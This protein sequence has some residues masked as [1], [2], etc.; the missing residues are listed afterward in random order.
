[1]LEQIRRFLRAVP[2]QPFHIR[3]SSGEIFKVDHPENAAIVGTRVVVAIPE[4]GDAV[5]IISPL[6]IVSVGGSQSVT[7]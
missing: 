4:E 5:E 2:F 6:H 1:M 7:A 3:A